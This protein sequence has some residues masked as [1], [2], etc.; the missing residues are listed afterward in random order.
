[1]PQ[2]Q[3][4]KILAR[5]HVVANAIDNITLTLMHDLDQSPLTT[6]EALSLPGL[7]D[8]AVRFVVLRLVGILT[9]FR[10]LLGTLSREAYGLG[11][12]VPPFPQMQE[13]LEWLWT[14]RQYVLRKK[15]WP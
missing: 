12:S 8:Q 4:D 3:K 2:S 15:K 7:H 5:A 13:F 6:E 11:V 10:D 9:P 14:D 1:M